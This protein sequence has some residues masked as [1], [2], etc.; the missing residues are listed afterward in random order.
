M[1]FV[2][3]NNRLAGLGLL[4][5]LALACDP[6]SDDTAPEAVDMTSGGTGSTP[7]APGGSDGESGGGSSGESSGPPAAET[8]AADGGSTEGGESGIDDSESDGGSSGGAM[9]LPSLLWLLDAETGLIQPPA[10]AHDGADAS[11]GNCG[12]DSIAYVMGGDQPVHSG[13][14]SLAVRFDR[15][16]LD[17]NPDCGAVRAFFVQSDVVQ[18]EPDAEYW[19]GWAVYVPDEPG[20]TWTVARWATEGQSNK[21]LS[22]DLRSD[23]TWRFKSTQIGSNGSFDLTLTPA[24]VDF[25]AGAAD[26]WHEFAANFVMTTDEDAG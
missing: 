10:E 26:T 2:G 11:V 23:L 6:A 9:S 8:T 16:W 12:D 4:C 22:L 3:A 19:H 7:K 24:T 13:A 17:D 15:A 20:D 21:A 14:A 25:G 5:S 1:A 18:I